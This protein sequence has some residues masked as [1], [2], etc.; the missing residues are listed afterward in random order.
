MTTIKMTN[1]QTGEITELIINKTLSA[2]DTFRLIGNTT[3][4]RAV[5]IRSILGGSVKVVDGISLDGRFRTSAR[6]EDT[7]ALARGGAA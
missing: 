3:P 2:G 5:S 1:A 7:A 6:I 4:F